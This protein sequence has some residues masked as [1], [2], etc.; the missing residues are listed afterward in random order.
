MHSG[1]EA[2]RTV[3]IRIP[4]WIVRHLHDYVNPWLNRA[5]LLRIVGEV[6]AVDVSLVEEQLAALDDAGAIQ[7]RQNV[8]GEVEVALKPAGSTSL[9]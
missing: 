5:D 8:L 6:A 7:F 2:E 1:D 4:G 3:V 9:R